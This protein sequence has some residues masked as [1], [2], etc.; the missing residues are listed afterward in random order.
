MKNG[1]LRVMFTT[2]IPLAL[3]L[4]LAASPGV[5]A[6]QSPHPITL[7]D[8]QAIAGVRD[9]DAEPPA[10][11]EPAGGSRPRVP[12]PI[13][14]DRYKFKQDVQ[15]Y[16]LSG[17]HNYIYLFDVATKKLERLTAGTSDESTPSWSPD[18]TR[19]AFLT[20]RAADPDRDPSG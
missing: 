6:Q 9:P 1:K 10:S 16:L 7:D 19:I 12:K 11:G 14:I 8:I 2:R 3:A 17:R 4:A 18:G 20:N 5:V 15:G 13:V